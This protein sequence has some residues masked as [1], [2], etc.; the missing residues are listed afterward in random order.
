MELVNGIEPSYH[1]NRIT[2]ALR[3]SDAVILLRL[4]AGDDKL[5]QPVAH[6]HRLARHAP[7]FQRRGRVAGREHGKYRALVVGEFKREIAGGRHLRTDRERRRK[8]VLQVGDGLVQN[9]DGAAQDRWSASDFQ[10]ETTR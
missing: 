6:V 1:L 5:E 2:C 4:R 7:T 9:G 8:R 3:R 10:G